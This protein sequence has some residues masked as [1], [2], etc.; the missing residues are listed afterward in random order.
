[1]KWWRTLFLFG[2]KMRI[3]VTWLAGPVGECHYKH[4]SVNLFQELRGSS[5]GNCVWCMTQVNEP[6]FRFICAQNKLYFGMTN[7][8][9][10]DSKFEC[11]ALIG[12]DPTGWWALGATKEI[13]HFVDKTFSYWYIS[14]RS[15]R[16][17]CIPWWGWNFRLVSNYAY[18]CLL[19]IVSRKIKLDCWSTCD[20]ISKYNLHDWRGVAIG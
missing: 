3:P 8:K 11:L 17:V 5:G 20:D 13:L 1:M 16:H 14:H 2:F 12:L 15:L 4:R 10:L 19:V 7:I 6:R 18:E 9:W